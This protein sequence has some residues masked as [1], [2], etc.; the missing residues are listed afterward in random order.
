MTDNSRTLEIDRAAREAL[1]GAYFGAVDAEDYGSFGEVFTD[2]VEFLPL[3]DSPQGLDAMVAWYRGEVTLTD[4]RHD[5]DRVIHSQDAT[6]VQGHLDADLQDG[7]RLEGRFADVFEF[8]E[9]EASITYLA[10]YIALQPH[11]P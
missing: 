9:R 4:M 11:I 5:V 7:R 6:V 1:I 3:G 2:D 8:D 10:I